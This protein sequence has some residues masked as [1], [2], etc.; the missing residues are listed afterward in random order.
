MSSRIVQR[1][2]SSASPELADEF[3]SNL[4]L[5]RDK[6]IGEDKV[7]KY[8]ELIREGS[9]H[10]VLWATALCLEDGLGY[11]LNG[12]HSSEAFLDPTLDLSGIEVI[13]HYWECATKDDMLECL[14]NYE[15]L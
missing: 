6:P 8:R 7:R 10:K 12:S 11:R 3:L 2:T 5:P 15:T 1:V 14:V 9:M 4:T 13:H